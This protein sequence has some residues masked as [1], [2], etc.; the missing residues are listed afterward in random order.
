MGGEPP[1]HLSAWASPGGLRAFMPSEV[2]YTG[3]D[4]LLEEL[5]ALDLP[6]RIVGVLGNGQQ[7]AKAAHLLVQR[8]DTRG[9]LLRVAHNPD[10]LHHVV[11]RQGIVGHAGVDF[12]GLNQSG[13]Q[14]VRPLML[15][16]VAAKDRARV[17]ALPS[18]S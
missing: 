3:A 10:M 14:A 16:V 18:T 5:Q 17:P 4:F 13:A 12:G 1:T 15:R 9:A 11:D 8:A 2:R 6:R 7:V